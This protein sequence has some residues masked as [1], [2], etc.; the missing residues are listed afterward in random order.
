[1][2][3]LKLIK[4]GAA[5]RT[6]PATTREF[7]YR[8]YGHRLHITRLTLGI[9]EQ[10]AADAHGISLRTYRKWEAGGPQR[11]GTYAMVRFVKKY[12]VSLSWL[13]DGEADH[14]GNH[15][16]KGAKG[17]IAILPAEGPGR[18]N[19]HNLFDRIVPDPAA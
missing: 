3:G 15:L 18:R 1:M 13:L 8:L 5:N 7:S 17:K 9:T 4:G 16:A 14:I 6:S 19:A 2:T 10:E 12:D 11:G